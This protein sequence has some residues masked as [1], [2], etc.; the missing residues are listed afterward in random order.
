M[1]SPTSDEFGH[2]AKAIT[3][4]FERVS[5]RLG[6]S[7]RALGAHLERDDRYVRDRFN[8]RQDF[9]LDDIERIATLL[10]IEPETFVARAVRNYE[11]ESNV[12][13]GRFGGGDV[14]AL[15]EDELMQLPHAANRDD[16]AGDEE[17]PTP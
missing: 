1:Q 11:S 14:S 5:D 6:F 2:F 12:V 7:K 9:S 3:R 17:P 10:E 16:S 15:S 13:R 4:E 8:G